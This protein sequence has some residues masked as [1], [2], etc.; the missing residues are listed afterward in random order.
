MAYDVSEKFR[1]VFSQMLAWFMLKVN[2]F[3][4]TI[5]FMMSVNTVSKD[6]AISFIQMGLLWR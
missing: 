5:K 2:A 4:G 1:N 3:I 6:T